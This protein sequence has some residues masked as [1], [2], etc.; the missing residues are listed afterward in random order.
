MLVEPARH[1]NK[2][3]NSSLTSRWN[4]SI[5]ICDLSFLSMKENIGS[6]LLAKSAHY[7]CDIGRLLSL[8][9]KLSMLQS[10]L[11]RPTWEELVEKRKN[12]FFVRVTI[13]RVYY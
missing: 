10:F 11:E 4:F 9:T 5:L 12:S 7:Y 3:G 1:T 2:N 13:L 8:V 6:V